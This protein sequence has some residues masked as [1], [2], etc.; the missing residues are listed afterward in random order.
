MPV[1]AFA[2]KGDYKLNYLLSVLPLSLSVSFL[3]IICRQA[4]RNFGS[5]EPIP[6]WNLLGVSTRND[7][8]RQ[9]L[10]VE[11]NF[12]VRQFGPCVPL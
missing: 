11:A 2:D 1:I 3:L 10:V 4:A 6:C 9:F 8:L 7:G 12:A 5:A